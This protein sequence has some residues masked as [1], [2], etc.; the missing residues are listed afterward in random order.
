MT[1]EEQAAKLVGYFERCAADEAVYEQKARWLLG[2][3]AAN[4]WLRL[5]QTDLLSPEEVSV[6][7]KLV[8]ENK[9]EGS[10]WFELA[11]GV[12]HWAK[13]NGFSIPYPLWPHK[14]AESPRAAQEARWKSKE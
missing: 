7:V 10:G 1:P 8:G 12:S 11:P 5:I 3:D 4:E 9:Y 2:R 14:V 13:S 6:L